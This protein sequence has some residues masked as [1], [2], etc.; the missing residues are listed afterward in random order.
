MEFCERAEEVI[1]ELPFP[2][3]ELNPNKRLHWSVKAKIKTR[4]RESCRVLA[5]AQ[6]VK[7][8]ECAGKIRIAATIHMPDRRKRDDDNITAAFKAGRDGFADALGVDDNR[9]VMTWIVSD[10]VR[11]GGMIVLEF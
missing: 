3:K 4:Y 11:R 10:E 2:P 7:K 5:L 6:G 9:F 1:V 8:C